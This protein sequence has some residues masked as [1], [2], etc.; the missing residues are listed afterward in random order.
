MGQG[1]WWP[2]SGEHGLC[3]T[4]S[5]PLPRAACWVEVSSG[6]QGA[7]MAFPLGHCPLSSELWE[8]WASPCPGQGARL[9]EAR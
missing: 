5:V 2:H 3:D 7:R 1:V 6:G 4:A 9:R 8:V